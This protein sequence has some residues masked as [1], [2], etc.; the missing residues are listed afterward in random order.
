MLDN[1]A[2]ISKESVSI[3]TEELITHCYQLDLHHEDEASDS[4]TAVKNNPVPLRLLNDDLY[5]N[6]SDD[7]I[8]DKDY[9][10]DSHTEPDTDCDSSSVNRVSSN[11][12]LSAFEKDVP[13]SL[14]QND[15][16]QSHNNL[17]RKRK[18]Q[19]KTSIE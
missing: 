4:F 10:P 19:N 16:Q 1:D 14:C 12:L 17:P 13:N 11:L 2:N 18:V 9:Q 15:L 5:Q 3:L 6:N 8:K 7:S